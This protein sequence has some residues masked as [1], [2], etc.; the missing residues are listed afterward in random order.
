MKCL[1]NILSLMFNSGTPAVC[2]FLTQESPWAYAPYKIS[3]T[4]RYYQMSADLPAST[5]SFPFLEFIKII[6]LR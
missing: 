4:T 3:L 6:S 1:Q 5:G 2:F